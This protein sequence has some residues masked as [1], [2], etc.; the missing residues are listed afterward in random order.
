MKQYAILCIA[1][2]L[3]LLSCK[4]ELPNLTTANLPSTF[5]TLRSDSGYILQTPKGAIIRIDSNSFDVPAGS[6]INIEVK[7]A[8]SAKDILLAG[9]TTTSD[10]K[11]LRSGGMF[12]FNVTA[13]GK[14]VN[15]VKPIHVSMPTKNVDINMQL[16]KGIVQKDSTINWV[17][18][19]PLDSSTDKKPA[20]ENAPNTDDSCFS[21]D[22]SYIPLPTTTI[23]ELPIDTTANYQYPTEAYQ[24]DIDQSGWYNTDC[25]FSKGQTVTTA[26]VIADLN[27]PSGL[28]MDVYLCIPK[29][30]VLAKSW[31]TNGDTYN[32][33]ESPD[34]T[35]P[36]ADS[37]TMILNDQAIIF[38]VGR[39]SD[40]T[41]YYGISHF[42][43]NKSQVITVAVKKALKD[44]TLEGIED[45]VLDKSQIDMDEPQIQDEV[46]PDSTNE[47]MRMQI[48]RVPCGQPKDTEGVV[49]A[50]GSSVVYYYK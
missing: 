10:G 31:Q 26:S 40:S 35:G 45:N 33:N 13:D 39:S 11:L 20:I 32:F 41:F 16:Y 25:L 8:Y 18:P 29:R 46:N 42:T 50:M 14:P 23:A 43:V 21:Y 38:A 49:E 44:E 30:G 34:G 9:L 1:A 6:K 15:I 17:D 22:T 4:K 24:F 2:I 3:L 7:E 19:Q 5:I 27:M 36:G 48:M 28:T 37:I 12:Y 47:I